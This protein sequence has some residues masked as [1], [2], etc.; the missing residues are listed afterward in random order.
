MTTTGQEEL[1]ALLSEA[2]HPSDGG[3]PLFSA[4]AALV[5]DDGELLAREAVGRTIDYL[6]DGGTAHQG[7]SASLGTLFDLASVTKA[8]VTATALAVL[9][10][11][12][13]LGSG[14]SSLARP[15][16]LLLPE[17][18][19]T[20]FAQVTVLELLTHRSGLPSEWEDNRPGPDAWERF[21]SLP[22][23][24]PPGRGH[25]YSCVGFTWLGLWLEELS[26]LPL[27]VLMEQRLLGPLGLKL[28]GYR[29]SIP[30]ETIAATEVQPGRGLV[31]GE[32]HD[33]SAWALG[34]VS[35]NAGL[36]STASELLTFVEMLRRNG[37]HC[38]VRILPPEAV[39]L[40][41]TP[42]PGPRSAGYDQAV[43]LRVGEPWLRA[44]APESRR[45]PAGHGGYTGTAFGFVPSGSRSAVLLSNR[46]HPRRGNDERFAAFRLRLM[47]LAG[48]L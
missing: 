22:L 20:P 46:V 37:T 27:D 12:G 18:H 29:P 44:L 13:L 10:D 26:G 8:F 45:I 9:S 14:L 42:A 25:A 47:E 35:G 41:T 48:A 36:F 32:V 1:S 6:D 31:H 15:V 43:G 38:G 3:A 11:K 4:A 33:E 2:L 39:R 34:G 5:S 19:R 16:A 40:M 7:P 24:V 23:Q 30:L 17:F 21:R 28:T